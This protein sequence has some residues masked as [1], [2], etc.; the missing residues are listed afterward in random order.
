VRIVLPQSATLAGTVLDE[1]T[2]KPLTG[3]IV[4]LDGMT[5]GA[6]ELVP[7]ATTDERGAFSLVGVPPGPFSVRVEREGYKSRI[8]SGLRTRG[9]SVV[10]EDITLRP[11]GDGGAGSELEGIGA[12]LAPSPAGIVVAGLV[13]G[14]PAS[15]VGLRRGDRLARIDG[16]SAEEMTLTDAIQRLRGPE[17]SRVTIAVLR[18]GEGQIE[19]TVMRSR[20]ER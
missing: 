11:R 20:I 10:R 15:Q 1:S 17:G 9:A 8:V 14:G 13:E 12:I 6:P 5:S 19:V 4:H 16:V 18:D 7:P 2:R 3:A